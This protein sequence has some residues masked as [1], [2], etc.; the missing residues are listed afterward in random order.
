MTVLTTLTD[1]WSGKSGGFQIAKQPMS[2][3]MLDGVAMSGGTASG[4]P[5]P[6]II[7]SP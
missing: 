7:G 6:I 3:A 2:R 1:D 4:L 5:R